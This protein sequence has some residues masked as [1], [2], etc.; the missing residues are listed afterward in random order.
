MI[1]KKKKKKKAVSDSYLMAKWR[2]AV[3][4]KYDSRCAF[5]GSV[6]NI[7]CHHIIKVRDKLTRWLLQ[8]GICLC[9]KCHGL[10][11]T[12]LGKAKVIEIIGADYDML[13]D[14]E[15]ITYKE[16][17]SRECMTDDEFRLCRLAAL[18]RYL[19]ADHE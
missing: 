11:G 19:E 10:A 12:L 9:H 15:L 8:N 1:T 17:L 2:E 5:C 7:E 18:K 6:Y 3:R 16:Y 14:L 13:L 4:K